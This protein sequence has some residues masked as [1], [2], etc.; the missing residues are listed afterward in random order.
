MLEGY[1]KPLN[2]CYIQ[3][4]ILQSVKLALKIEAIVKNISTLG[5]IYLLVA[6]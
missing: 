1:S 3:L 4:G 6:N 2:I 5:S